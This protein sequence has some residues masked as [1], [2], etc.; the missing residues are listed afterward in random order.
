MRQRDLAGRVSCAQGWLCSI[1]HGRTEPSDK[2][3]GRIASELGTTPA[4]LKG[5][6]GVE[7]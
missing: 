1:E 5:E 3:L 4:V 7:K 2:L 6:T